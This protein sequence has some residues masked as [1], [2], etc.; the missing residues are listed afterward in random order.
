MINWKRQHSAAIVVG[1]VSNLKEMFF[2]LIIV[3]IFGQTSQTDTNYTLFFLIFV[4]IFSVISGTWK[5]G[6]FKYKLEENELQVK[7]GL[8]QKKHRYIRKERVQSID[9]NAKLV[10]RIFGL[11]ELKI[12]TAGGGAEPEFRIIALKKEEAN[13]I[14]KE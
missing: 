12:E 13:F 6:T 14:K 7:R 5:W 8:L 4:I 2:T 11:V 10:Q 3:F 1:M 9:I